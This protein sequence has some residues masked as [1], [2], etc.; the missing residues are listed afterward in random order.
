M[1]KTGQLPATG[2]WRAAWAWAVILV[3]ALR[4]GLGVTM[5]AAWMVVKPNLPAQ[6]LADRSRYDGLPIPITF[7]GDAALS[8][9]VRWDA[10]H[11][12]N[13][14]R[15]GYFEVS[16]GDS[17]YYPL[18]PL[19]TRYITWVTGGDYVVGGLL[20]STLAA[21]AAL[22][23]L[24]RLAERR[25]GAD[26]ARRTV[27]ALAVYP[28]AVF[29]ISPFTEALFLALT[30]GAFLAA[31]ARRWWLTGLLG[32]LASL[33][34]G[35]GILTVAA[36]AW[37]AWEQWRKDGLL[38]SP[39]WAILRRAAPMAI[40]LAFPLL[41]GLAFIGWRHV[42]GFPSM[43]QV[44]NTYSP[45]LV[46]IDPVSG[47]WT[48]IAQWIN[49]RDL[50]TTLEIFSALTFLG[51]TMAMV[52]NR[53][54]WEAEWLIYMSVNLIV[55]LSKHAVRASYLQSLARYVLVLFP[56]FI[57]MGDWLAHR[58]PWLRF[59]ILVLSSTLLIG[60]SALYALWWFIG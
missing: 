22:A 35:P 51:L 28:T 54:W 5:G 2:G 30:L 25:Y 41:G 52:V 38:A 49:V 12:L 7:P 11:L 27:V 36:L 56:A 50:P 15:L 8:V 46:F 4:V 53:R 23:C 42:V 26:S 48:A 60:L 43:T 20:V 57:V 13:L 47:L 10:V 16:E 32:A 1:I 29:L 58:G 14:A 39:D 21:M 3:L 19:I 24:Y 44:L 33:T 17:V 45:G 40:G 31:Y 55:L 59:A 18:Y 6:W 34:R 9:W 37:I